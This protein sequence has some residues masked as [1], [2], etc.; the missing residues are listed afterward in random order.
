MLGEILHYPLDS[1]QV[2]KLK[3]WIWYIVD[4]IKY[5]R[6]VSRFVT[7]ETSVG[8]P[9]KDNDIWLTKEDVEVVKRPFTRPKKEFDRLLLTTNLPIWFL[10]FSTWIEALREG[11]VDN[12][13]MITLCFFKIKYFF[14]YDES[15]FSGSESWLSSR[16][17]DSFA[18]KRPSSKNRWKSYWQTGDVLS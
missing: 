6:T 17:P 8:S 16:A 1:I 15:D 10:K 5:L 12:S 3:F 11:N 7:L 14:D 13:V 2:L 18:P 9:V 4:I